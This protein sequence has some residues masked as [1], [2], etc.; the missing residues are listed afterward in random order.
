MQ[1]AT[2]RE[3]LNVYSNY[4]KCK[5]SSLQLCSKISTF[6]RT[7]LLKR[8]INQLLQISM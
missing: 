2:D 4:L 3:G 1:R 7:E 8:V 5:I 6:Q